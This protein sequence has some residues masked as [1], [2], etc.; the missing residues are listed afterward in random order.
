MP[1]SSDQH[2]YWNLYA[3]IG[4]VY[5]VCLFDQTVVSKSAISSLFVG[6]SQCVYYCW[7]LLLLLLLWN[8]LLFGSGG[9]WV[10]EA[11]CGVSVLKKS[12]IALWECTCLQR[13]IMGYEKLI[14]YK[15]LLSGRCW[16]EVALPA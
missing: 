7:C 2:V 16:L 15:Y 9:G 3:K 10:E 6:Y 4:I 8:A 13:Q 14:S 11:G 1:A 5:V 12:V